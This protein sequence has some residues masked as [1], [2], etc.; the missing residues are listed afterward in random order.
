MAALQDSTLDDVCKI[1]ARPRR[2]LARLHHDGIAREDGTDDRRNEVM[3]RVVPADT[4]RDHTERFVDDGIGFIEHEKICGA[5]G[6]RESFLAVVDGPLQL[7]RSDKYL[8]KESIDAGLA[9]V[10]AACCDNFFLMVEQISAASS[11]STQASMREGANLSSVL[12][13]CRRCTKVVLAQSTCAFFA[14]RTAV[15]MACL[16]FGL[17]E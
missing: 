6:R 12:S 7:F 9:G 5:L 16:S 11:A 14:R 13:T 17:M 10:E 4:C 15:S 1:D 3:E 2:L 8:T